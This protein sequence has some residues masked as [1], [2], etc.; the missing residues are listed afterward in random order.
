MKDV[1]LES[2]E[3][4]FTQTAYTGF[5]FGLMAG[6]GV[7]LALFGILAILAFALGAYL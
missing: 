3:K 4:K 6:L 7:G 2:A 5:K 1:E